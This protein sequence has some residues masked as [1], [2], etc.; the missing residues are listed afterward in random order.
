MLSVCLWNAYH[1]LNIGS[2][3]TGVTNL[4][5]TPINPALIMN[6]T[7]LIHY[8]TI[9]AGRNQKIITEICLLYM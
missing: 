5:G 4:V 6:H 1:Y 3:P 9:L 7:T 2:L 8:D